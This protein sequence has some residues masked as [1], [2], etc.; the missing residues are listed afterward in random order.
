MDVFMKNKFKLIF[1]LLAKARQC[2]RYDR[3]RENKKTDTYV[4]ARARWFFLPRAT[5]SFEATQ[6]LC[7]PR[8]PT[9]PYQKAVCIIR[10]EQ[11]PWVSMTAGCLLIYKC[12]SRV[13]IKL[14]LCRRRRPNHGN[15]WGQVRTD[16]T[17]VGCTVV[18]MQNRPKAGLT[19][20]SGTGLKATVESLSPQDAEVWPHSMVFFS[21]YKKKLDTRNVRALQTHQRAENSSYFL[22][23]RQKSCGFAVELR[24]EST[25]ADTARKKEI[26]YKEVIFHPCIK[27]YPSVAQ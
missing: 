4:A 14:Y 19:T 17:S 5:K 26:L 20:S 24:N 11:I 21:T 22:L 18:L 1:S 10:E 3:T 2:P 23:K 15:R 27:P 7:V 16:I 6:L 8:S 9:D 13:T 25:S 12:G